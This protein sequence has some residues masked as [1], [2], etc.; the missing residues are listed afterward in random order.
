METYYTYICFT[1]F[2]GFFL[3]KCYKFLFF[4]NN[5][6][7]IDES[8]DTVEVSEEDIDIE[9]GNN[10][11]PIY[12]IL[13]GVNYKNTKSELKGC[14]NDA[15]NIGKMLKENYGCNDKH[16]CFLV[17][18]QQKEV[19][20]LFPNAS[21]MLP[22]KKNICSI[23]SKHSKFSQNNLIKLL[24]HF[25]GHGS[26]VTDF[27]NDELDNK[28]EV[29]IPVDCKTNGYIKDDFLNKC[30][31]EEYSKN[32][33]L[34]IITD[35]CHSG[36]CMDLEN[37]YENTYD[38]TSDVQDNTYKFN[39]NMISGCRDS[40]TSLDIFTHSG[41][42]GALTQA[43]LDCCYNLDLFDL[44]QKEWREFQKNINSNMVKKNFHQRPVYSNSN[45]L[46]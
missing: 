14:V 44:S 43:F 32:C 17:D 41:F 15:I 21:V 20:D 30:L 19:K 28:D 46:L 34:T 45:R 36:T 42:Q 12:A 26:Q 27:S 29:I 13:I 24:V 2:L 25:S 11:L 39:I 35:C 6:G 5:T 3:V 23:L 9:I 10:V 38:N 22:T 33:K 31:V 7:Q 18:S 16:F 37:T 8:H 4:N 40:Q 1:A